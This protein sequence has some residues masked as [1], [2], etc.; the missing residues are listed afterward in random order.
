[1]IGDAREEA[2]PRFHDSGAS[3]NMYWW[4]IRGARRLMQGDLLYVAAYLGMSL[5]IWRCFWRITIMHGRT[6][7]TEKN[8]DCVLD[9]EPRKDTHE[10][11][12]ERMTSDD[13][14]HCLYLR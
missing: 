5:A 14:E 3:S 4:E 7:T 11:I 10:S 9:H 6:A 12:G 13:L 8:D 1:M 2:H